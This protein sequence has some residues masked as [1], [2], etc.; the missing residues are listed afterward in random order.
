MS[1]RRWIEIKGKVNEKMFIIPDKLKD[2]IKKI[3]ETQKKHSGLN[4]RFPNFATDS[5]RF[6]TVDGL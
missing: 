1:N 6:L 4:N 3:V 2:V 5:N